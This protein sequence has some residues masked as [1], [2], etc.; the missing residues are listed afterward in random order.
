MPRISS[1]TIKSVSN[2]GYQHVTRGISHLLKATTDLGTAL[3]LTNVP[4]LFA[5]RPEQL[6]DS[7]RDLD[8]LVA[9]LDAMRLQFAE[10]VEAAE[11]DAWA[12][13]PMS[14][15]THVTNCEEPTLGACQ[16]DLAPLLIQQ[17][18]DSSFPRNDRH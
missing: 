1:T 7:Y 8:A 13:L 18:A 5:A 10:Y 14:Y 15:C 6:R 11:E 2:S 4:E 9:Q 3:E 17:W 12:E 16:T